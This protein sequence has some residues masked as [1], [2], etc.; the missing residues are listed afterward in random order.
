MGYKPAVY[1]R[2]SKSSN[3]MCMSH[4]QTLN[5]SSCDFFHLGF[6]SFKYI[7]VPQTD[8]ICKDTVNLNKLYSSDV[9][10]QDHSKTGQSDWELIS[11]QTLLEMETISLE[12]N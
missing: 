8:I 4:I 10:W 11:Q 6:T 2:K 3:T 7:S 9:S 5:T 1:S 12:N